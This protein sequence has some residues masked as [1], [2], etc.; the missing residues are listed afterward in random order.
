MSIEARSFR[1]TYQPF[2]RPTPSLILA[3][4]THSPHTCAYP[5]PP[6]VLASFPFPSVSYACDV[7]ELRYPQSRSRNSQT[8]ETDAGND[9]SSCL[10]SSS[11]IY[12]D[13]PIYVL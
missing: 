9:A 13:V 12:R 5:L 8:P 10:L 6:P 7:L 11:S 3:E 4:H 2:R 1:K